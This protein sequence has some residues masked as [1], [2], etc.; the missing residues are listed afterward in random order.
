MVKEV[1]L[2]KLQED[3]VEIFNISR[4]TIQRRVNEMQ[5]TNPE[6][7]RL[8]KIHTGKEKGFKNIIMT[9]LDY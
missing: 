2:E 8:F 9:P 5:D 7:Y 4:R 6:L 3:A 1:N